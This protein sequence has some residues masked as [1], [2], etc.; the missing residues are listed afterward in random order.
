MKTYK[1][2]FQGFNL[3]L[4]NTRQEAESCIATRVAWNK[5]NDPQ[6]VAGC[7]IDKYSIVENITIDRVDVIVYTCIFITGSSSRGIKGSI[8]NREDNYVLLKYVEKNVLDK[9]T[10]KDGKH[11]RNL[12]VKEI[13]VD[14]TPLNCVRVN[15]SEDSFTV[16]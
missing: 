5:A 12:K 16:V 4:F 9:L 3:D 14:E 8:K 13:R 10:S 15:S 6:N 7:D 11:F 2:Y 1:T